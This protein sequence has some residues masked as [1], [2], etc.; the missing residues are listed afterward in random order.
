IGR[1]VHTDVHAFTAA[2][3]RGDAEAAARLYTG[4]FLD[5][6][7]LADLEAWEAWVHG[8]RTLYARAFRK[9]SRAWLD[10]RRAAAPVPGAAG[11]ARCGLRPAPSADEAQPRLIEALAAAG[12]RAEAIRQ[13]ETYARLLEPDGL[14]PLDETVA[15]IERVRATA[16]AWPEP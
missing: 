6:V 13:Y 9:A 8:R 3:E 5:S 4:A 10:A 12:D 15:L 7:H 14:R 2:L 11:A 1:A 16:A